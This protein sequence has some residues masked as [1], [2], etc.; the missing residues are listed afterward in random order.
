MKQLIKKL[1]LQTSARVGLVRLKT[2][3][4]ECVLGKYDGSLFEGS[5]KLSMSVAKDFMPLKRVADKRG[6]TI[7]AEGDRFMNQRFIT[8]FEPFIIKIDD[9]G[10]K[11]RAK[12]G[13]TQTARQLKSIATRVSRIAEDALVPNSTEALNKILQLLWSK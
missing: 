6:F 11:G 4:V 7:I 1:Q 9:D 10:A 5:D 8:T 2:N 3:G 13:S 12:R